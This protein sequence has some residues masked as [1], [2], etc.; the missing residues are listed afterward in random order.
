MI[1]GALRRSRMDASSVE[2]IRALGRFAGSAEALALGDR[3]EAHPPVLKT[4]DR[5]GNRID[6]VVYDPAYHQLM[7][8]HAVRHGLHAAPPWMDPR[9]PDAHLI[10]ALKF[11][12]WSHVDAGHGCPIS[13]TYSVVPALRAAPSLASL[14]EPL[15]CATRYDPELRE[16]M[17][18]RGLLAGMS[19]TEK[20]GGSDV[21]ANTTDALPCSDGTYRITGHKWFTSAPPMSDLFLVLAQAPNGLSCFLVPRVLPDGTRNTFNLQ[22]LKDKLGNRSNASS[23]VEYDE[24]IGWPVG[25]EGR[26]VKIIVEMVNLTRLDCVLGTATAMRTGVAQAAHHAAHRSAF[27]GRVSTSNR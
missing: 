18:K 3:A 7:G 9:P 19:M 17:T 16:P 13:M 25:D 5:Y 8:G 20:Q 27:G 2:E 10:R 26:G 15:L 14:Y 23:E 11:S 12:V 21:R 22:R 4:H 6:E 1:A 24:T